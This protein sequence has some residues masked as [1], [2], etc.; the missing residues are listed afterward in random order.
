M[1]RADMD[2]A[3]E[4]WGTVKGEGV[5]SDPKESWDLPSDLSLQIPVV[6]ALVELGN[7]FH[8]RRGSENEDKR[9]QRNIRRDLLQ[10]VSQE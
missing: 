1:K 10:T 6:G 5:E 9:K 4:K 7:E 8:L 3:S 2:L